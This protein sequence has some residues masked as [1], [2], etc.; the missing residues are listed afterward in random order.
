MELL[1]QIQKRAMKL[2]SGMDHLPYKDRLRKLGLFSLE[3]D[4]RMETL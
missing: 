2:L 3:S 4:S 1:E